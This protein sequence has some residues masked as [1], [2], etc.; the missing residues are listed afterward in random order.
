MRVFDFVADAG[1]KLAGLDPKVFIDHVR[2]CGL[3]AAGIDITVEGSLVTVIGE[4]AAQDELEK[5]VL[6]L[7]NV[8]GVARVKADCEVR[9]PGRE[10]RF[11]IVKQGD[12]LSSIA[13][14]QYGDAG[15]YMVIFEANKPPLT[16][17]D[18]IFPGTLLRIP[19]EW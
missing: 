14:G 19:E 6:V 11:V 9:T 12:T 13:R 18:K 15:K 1:E 4:V 10:S 16:D 2:Q 8:R 17:P 5:I 3:D 7:G